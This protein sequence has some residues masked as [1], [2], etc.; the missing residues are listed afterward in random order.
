MILAQLNSSIFLK[1]FFKLLKKKNLS[2][3]LR[4][5]SV[6]SFIYAN[7]IIIIIILKWKLNRFL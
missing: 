4:D 3:L 7:Y 5:V 2:N 6:K 1:R